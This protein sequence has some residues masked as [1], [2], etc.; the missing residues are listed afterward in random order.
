[1]TKLLNVIA[2]TVTDGTAT[3]TAKSFL[4]KA[5][6]WMTANPFWGAVVIVGVA[7]VVCGLLYYFGAY[8][9]KRR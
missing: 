3:E 9:R 7:A 6:E 5:N 1:M 2:D 8:K 4:E